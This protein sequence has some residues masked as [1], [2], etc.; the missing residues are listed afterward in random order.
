MVLEWFAIACTVGTD[1]RVGPRI[2]CTGNHR[3][4]T[5]RSAP[6]LICN[7]R[8]RPDF[9]CVYGKN[10]HGGHGEHWD[11]S[12]RAM[13]FHFLFPVLPAL[14]VVD[15]VHAIANRSRLRKQVQRGGVADR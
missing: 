1:L 14:P 5:N 13:T 4:P 7:P 8:S 11:K 12:V 15:T 6:T 9:N 10:N 2:G 3:G